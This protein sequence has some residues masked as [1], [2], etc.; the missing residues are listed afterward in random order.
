MNEDIKQ[1]LL[2]LLIKLDEVCE[3]HHLRYYLA[4]GTCLGALRHK[5]FIPWDHDID[6]LMPI[7]DARK[8]IRYQDEFGDRYFVQSKE[9]DPEYG[10]IAYKLRDSETACIWN[11]YRDCRFNQG[12]SIDIYPFY[13]AP[14][15][16]F[17][18]LVNI[19]RSY[20]LKMLTL[21]DMPMNHKGPA[22][23]AM[24]LFTSFYRGK[25]GEKK[26]RYLQ[27][28]LEEVKNGREILDYYGQDITL[29]S[30]ITYPA[31]WFAEPK[32]LEFEG[33]LF[34]GPTEPEKY[35]ERRYGDYMTL[36]PEEK[37]I[38]EFSEPGAIIDPHRSYLKYYEE[39]D[40]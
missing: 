14:D 13:Y 30:A 15:S 39:M 18:L 4:F 9:T 33:L 3:R 22:Q 17:K 19:W 21:G 8:L 40:K 16:R 12:L 35:M 27:R 26:R 37:R 23:S 7:E 24:R 29:F 32:K 1:V 28:K 38:E 20:F 10:A 2:N 11:E 6:V 34:N 25:R 5:G 31:E 36:P